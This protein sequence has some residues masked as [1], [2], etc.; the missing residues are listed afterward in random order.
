MQLKSVG[1]EKTD[2]FNNYLEK[3]YRKTATLMANSCK[4]VR[5]CLYLI[6]HVVRCSVVT[7]V[8]SPPW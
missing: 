2:M 4:A 1:K 3:T 7:F 8:G 5:W 6:S